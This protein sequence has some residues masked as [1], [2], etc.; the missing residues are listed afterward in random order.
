MKQFTTI[1]LLLVVWLPVLLWSQKFSTLGEIYDYLPGDRF[2]M[3]HYHCCNELYF[4]IEEITILDKLE[5]D[6]KISYTFHR[7]L[8]DYLDTDP[9]ELTDTSIFLY[10]DTLIIEDPDFILFGEEDELYSYPHIYHGRTICTDFFWITNTNGE[11]RY[12]NGLGVVYLGW[13]M[14]PDSSFKVAD[15]LIYYQKGNETWGTSILGNSA[16]SAHDLI[17]LFPNPVTDVL[18]ITFPYP[19]TA[20]HQIQIFNIQGKR[21][22]SKTM[23]HEDIAAGIQLNCSQFNRGLYFLYLSADKSTV[24]AKFVKE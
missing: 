11:R 5:T 7:S 12:A 14:P 22:I 20:I 1:G 8:F 16:Q 3:I 24:V 13:R 18:R 17:S 6:Q 23:D 19:K 2:H 21:I 9:P 4:Q 10:V 15:S